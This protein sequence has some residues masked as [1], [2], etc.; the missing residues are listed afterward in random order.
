[1]LRLA[2]SIVTFSQPI[3]GP[4]AQICARTMAIGLPHWLDHARARTVNIRFQWM[5]TV[6]AHGQYNHRFDILRCSA[7]ECGYVRNLE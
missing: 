1:M 4:N 6:R 2:T 7:Y 5:L 3:I